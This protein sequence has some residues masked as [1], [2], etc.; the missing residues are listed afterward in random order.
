MSHR[1]PPAKPAERKIPAQKKIELT[2]NGYV[3]I[4]NVNDCL[5]ADK[6]YNKISIA[7]RMEKG[8]GK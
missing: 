4:K 5:R 7:W 1:C 2:K 6:N 8:P 3:F